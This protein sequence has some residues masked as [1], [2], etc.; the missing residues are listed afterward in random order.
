M[1]ILSASTSSWH[2]EG[3]FFGVHDLTPSDDDCTLIMLHGGI[4]QLVLGIGTY[5]AD[6]PNSFGA[7]GCLTPWAATQR[8]ACVLRGGSV[9]LTTGRPEQA[10]GQQT[11]EKT[12]PGPA[13]RGTP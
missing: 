7:K 5:R 10:I 11:A 4:T 3:D 2:W 9:A 8:R 6:P 1:T 12:R 13:Y